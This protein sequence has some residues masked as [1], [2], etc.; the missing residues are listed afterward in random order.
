[1]L[2][3]TSYALYLVHW[4]I[5]VGHRYYNMEM[6]KDWMEVETTS[7]LRLSTIKERV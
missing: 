5:C 4:P 1:M 2:G 7:E 3:D 6:Y